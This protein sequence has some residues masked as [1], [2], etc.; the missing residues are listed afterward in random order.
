MVVGS[1]LLGNSNLMRVCSMPAFSVR[2][3]RRVAAHSVLMDRLV[4]GVGFRRDAN[5]RVGRRLP[6][7]AR[8]GVA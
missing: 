1:Q 3:G 8:A 2:G 6:D 5:K 7:I 4:P